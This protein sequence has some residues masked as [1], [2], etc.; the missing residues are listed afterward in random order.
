MVNIEYFDA[1]M[2]GRSTGFPTTF[3]EWQVVNDMVFVRCVNVA[4]SCFVGNF[5]WLS[6]M[7]SFMNN[8]GFTWNR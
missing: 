2:V 6:T 7:K 5:A 1:T 3:K 8:I 4:H